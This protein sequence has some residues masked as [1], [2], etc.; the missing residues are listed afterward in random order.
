MPI[1]P[2]NAGKKNKSLHLDA[3]DTVR[4]KLIIVLGPFFY[5][6]GREK[7]LEKAVDNCIST[8]AGFITTRE[9]PKQKLGAT[10]MTESASTRN[11]V[12]GYFDKPPRNL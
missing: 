12:T 4:N 6:K 7:R 9:S 2:S 8:I 5:G 10:V 11:P 1:I 3:I